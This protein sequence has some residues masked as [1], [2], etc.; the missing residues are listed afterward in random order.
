M[1][2]DGRATNPTAHRC[3]TF[4]YCPSSPQSRTMAGWKGML[5]ES[6]GAWRV[7]VVAAAAVALRSEWSLRR[8]MGCDRPI[9]IK[10][11]EG[12]WSEWSLRRIMGCDTATNAT[13]SR[14]LR[15]NARCARSWV[16]TNDLLNNSTGFT[17]LEC[18]LRQIMGCDSSALDWRR[19]RR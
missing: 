11:L 5:H 13:R 4:S 6:C 1:R 12:V 15:Q 3:S 17:V 7:L 8:I 10:R 14:I 9:L 19:R 18:T 16:A 2:S